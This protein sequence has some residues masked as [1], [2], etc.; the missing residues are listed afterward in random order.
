[1]TYSQI[2][3]SS[4]WYDRSI[5]NSL[6]VITN[7]W[8]IVSQLNQYRFYATLSFN[9]P[10]DESKIYSLNLWEDFDRVVPLTHNTDYVLYDNKIF[11]LP[12]YILSKFEAKVSLHAT[13]IMINQYTMEKQF[14]DVFGLRFDHLLTQDEIRKAITAFHQ[15]HSTKLTIKDI[16]KSVIDATGFSTFR[17]QDRI[18]QDLSSTWKLYYA[19]DFISPSTFLLKLPEYTNGIAIASDQAR[20]SV[21]VHLIDMVKEVQTNYIVVYTTKRDE[22]ISKDSL[23][24]DEADR[25]ETKGTI[26]LED[27]LTLGTFNSRLAKNSYTEKPIFTTVQNSFEVGFVYDDGIYQLDYDSDETYDPQ[28]VIVVKED[29]TPERPYGFYTPSIT[30]GIG[31][32]FCVRVFNIV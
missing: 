21:M 9:V 20:I 1:M 17:I 32:A 26:S 25:F 18:S 3:V 22:G 29:I 6:S 15:V 30:N 12:S 16:Q 2:D 28:D 19:S 13:D 27:K 23:S 24:W 4:A 10:Y 7:T 14:G 5:A 11:L 8:D 31:D